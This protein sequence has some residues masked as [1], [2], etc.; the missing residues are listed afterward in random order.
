MKFI[1]PLMA[2]LIAIGAASTAAADT[3]ACE[4]IDITIYFS[5]GDAQLSPYAQTALAAELNQL[6]HCDITT[7]DTY[8][9]SGEAATQ[10]AAMALSS[11]RTRSVLAALT[12]SGMVIPDEA[13]QIRYDVEE[14]GQFAISRR[15]EM[16]LVTQPRLP[17]T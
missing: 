5:D 10:T 12:A 17:N 7:V 9:T 2:S 13:V 14:A 3:N 11:A 8:A 15:V 16:T 4:P 1:Q 6:E